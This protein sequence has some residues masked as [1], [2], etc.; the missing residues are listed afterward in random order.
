M[1]TSSVQ[2][3]QQQSSTHLSD[4]LQVY[5]FRWSL[6]ARDKQ[7]LPAGSWLAWLILA[8]RGFGKTRTGAETVRMWKENS[9]IIG[10]I[11]ATAGDLRDTMIE[12]DSGIM[13]ISPPWDRPLYEPSKRR[14]T[15][16]NGTVCLLRSADKPDGIR[17]LNLYKAWADE[18][19]SWRYPLAW[20]MLKLAVRLGD[21]PQVCVTTTPRPTKVIKDLV[22][23]SR[24]HVT[25]GSTY[26]NRDNLSPAFY[27]HIMEMYEGT[28]LGRQ[29]IH[30]EILEAIEGA[31][32]TYGLIDHNRVSKAPELTRIVVAIDPAVTSK[33]TS[34]E[35][36]IITAGLGTD[37]RVYILEDLSGIYT[38]ARWCSLAINALEQNKGDRIV[39]E[40]NNGGDL[41]ETILRG[42]APEVS[43][44]GVHASRGKVTR[45][46]PVLALY[47]RG[48]VKHVGQL[49]KLEQE[50]TSWDPSSSLS[51]GRIDA[52]V[53]AVTELS[54]GKGKGFYAG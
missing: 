46:E 38:P 35:T 2:S 27:E 20:D 36:G 1:Q 53:W 3:E 8:G 6:H 12:G 19:A 17:G 40:T 7:R 10:I 28:S 32:W 41:I 9:P 23:H 37:D 34:D 42:I 47:E 24:T 30:A 16:K 49:D 21:S 33:A 48:K 14:L 43:Y 51:P 5:R 25:T 45:A 44:K 4:L 22:K 39:G 29:E 52:M 54:L 26:E 13:A 11:G 31:L 18:L 15:F 50:M